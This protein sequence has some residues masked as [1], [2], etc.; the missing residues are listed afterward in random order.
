MCSFKYIWE[1][2]SN[3][4]RLIQRTTAS[5]TSFA[6]NLYTPENLNQD[7]KKLYIYIVKNKRIVFAFY[8][9]K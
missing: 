6:A 2:D 9:N 5:N 4:K 3:Y 8:F 1:Y 7:N